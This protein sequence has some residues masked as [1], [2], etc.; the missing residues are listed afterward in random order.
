MTQK[1]ANIIFLMRKK[2]QFFANFR[3]YRVYLQKMYIDIIYIARIA[4]SPSARAWRDSEK[5]KKTAKDALFSPRMHFYPQDAKIMQRIMWTSYYNYKANCPEYHVGPL[6]E[7]S[8]RRQSRRS[9]DISCQ[10]QRREQLLTFE[11]L[12]FEE[13]RERVKS[14]AS[15]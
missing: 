8:L 1:V 3:S 9:Y 11:K 5:M 15:T 6:S 13:S 10:R 12:M 2:S 4:R 7:R 14:R